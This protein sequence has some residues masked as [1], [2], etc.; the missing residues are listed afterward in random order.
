MD[1]YV[2]GDAPLDILLSICGSLDYKDKTVMSFVCKSWQT[3]MSL[4]LIKAVQFPPKTPWLMLAQEDIWGQSNTNSDDID[5]QFYDLSSG[6]ILNLR[7]PD[8]INRRCVGVGFGWLLTL[9]FHLEMTL[10]HPFTHRKFI[11]PSYSTFNNYDHD[12]E[13]EQLWEI[14]LWKAV[15]SANPWDSKNHDFNRDCVIMAFYGIG[16]AASAKLEDKIWT[17]ITEP[18]V[19]LC[20]D[21]VNYKSQFYLLTY[22]SLNA[23]SV[24]GRQGL[25]VPNQEVHS[26]QT[27]TLFLQTIARFPKKLRAEFCYL[28]ESL[29]EL[30]LVCRFIYSNEWPHRTKTFKVFKLIKNQNDEFEYEFIEVETLGNQALFLGRNASFSL[31]ATST[32]WCRGNCIYFTDDLLDFLK[33]NENG[34]GHDMGIYNLRDGTIEKHY[35]GESLSFFST[36]FWYI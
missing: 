27:S 26:I 8:T 12:D 30:L 29:G 4:I 23:Y 18:R 17:D 1:G 32:N 10:F 25:P 9:D 3:S 14:L 21:V 31:S 2:W 7:L 16:Y 33:S 28:V 13:F 35:K 22:H 24:D 36:P 6:E 34:A 11:L 15:A 5:R 20:Y 19:A